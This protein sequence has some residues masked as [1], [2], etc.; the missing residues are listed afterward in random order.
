MTSVERVK[1]L[2]SMEVDQSVHDDAG[3]IIA[4][5]V[6]S[7]IKRKTLEAVIKYLKTY[8]LEDE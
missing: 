6:D 3:I 5:R 7:V 8:E 4:S 1:Q 2:L